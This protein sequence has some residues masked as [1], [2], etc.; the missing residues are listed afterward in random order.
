MTIWNHYI[1]STTVPGQGFLSI[2]SNNAPITWSCNVAGQNES[3]C[4]STKR[5]PMATTLDRMVNYFDELLPI[6]SNGFLVTWSCKI[7]WP[8]KTIISPLP[9]SMTNKLGRLVTYFEGLLTITSGKPLIRSCKVTW[10]TKRVYLYYKSVYGHQ[11][12]QNDS[13]PWWVP[14]YNVTLPFNQMGLRDYVRN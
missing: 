12:W 14:A 1:S 10:Q 4:I 3:H 7:M 8:T 11:T 6:K 13:F 5:V 9:V 2:K